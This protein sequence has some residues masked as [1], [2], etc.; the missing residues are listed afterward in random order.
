MRVAIIG[1]GTMGKAMA[2]SILRSK[3]AGKQEVIISEP[4]TSIREQAARKYGVPVTDDNSGAVGNSD[5]VVLAVKPQE[6]VAVA[7]QISKKLNGQLVISIAAGITLDTLC[8]KLDYRLV[9]RAMPNTPA[10]VG[11]GMTAWTSVPGL[12]EKQH[13][14]ART[15]LNSMGEEQYFIDEKYLDMATAVS[16]SGPAYVFLFVEAFIDAGVHIGL[17]REVASRLVIETITGSAEVI[18][19]LSKHPA[20]LKNMVTSPGGTTSEALLLLESGGMRSL[21]INAVSAAYAKAKSLG[22]K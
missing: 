14:M 5:V 1:G 12:S 9:V 8:R 17:T 2:H 7:Q 18:K 10:Q 3:L 19:K 21:I 22:T 13:E 15:I 20:E 6:I 16:G 4:V 11:R